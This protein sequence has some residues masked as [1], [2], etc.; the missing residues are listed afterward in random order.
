M[1]VVEYI[2]VEDLFY[3]I[4]ILN[5]VICFYMYFWVIYFIFYFIKNMIYLIKYGKIK[6]YNLWQKKIK[7]NRNL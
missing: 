4:I 5:F 1:L 7:F 2:R 6:M 3:I